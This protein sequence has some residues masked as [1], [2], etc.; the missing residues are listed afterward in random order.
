MSKIRVH[1]EMTD[2]CRECGGG[3]STNAA[4]VKTQVFVM[5]G[6]STPRAIARRVMA[7]FGVRGFRSDGWS[8][9]LSWRRGAVGIWAV[10]EVLV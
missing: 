8:G 4:W 6:T 3:W 2:L 9:P 1:A 10:T 7:A 5:P